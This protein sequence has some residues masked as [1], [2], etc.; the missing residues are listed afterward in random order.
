MYISILTMNCLVMTNR[1]LYVSARLPQT[2]NATITENDV[3]ESKYPSVRDL[4]GQNEEVYIMDAKTH[5]NIGR[6]LNVSL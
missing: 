2:F 3:H 1:W 6:Y 5:G 4:Y